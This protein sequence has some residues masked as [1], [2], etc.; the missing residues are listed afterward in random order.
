MN[1]EFGISTLVGTLGLST[2]VLGLAIG[3][4]LMS[5]L[6]EFYGRRPIYLSSW[7]MFLVWIIPSA[8][9]GNPETI[10]VTRFFGGFAGS[11]FL[12][13]AGGTVSDVFS[14]DEIQA[15]MTIISLSPFIGPSL[16]PL[17][18]G[19]INSN[20]YW[21]WT[22]YFLL[23]WSTVVL[24]CIVFLAPET[25]HPVRLREK[26]RR[27]RKETGDERWRAPMENM[28]KSIARTVGYS[29]LRPFQLL[30][31]E[32]MCLL[33][34]VFSAILLGCLYLFFGA[35]SL[36]FGGVYGFNLWQTGLAFLGI[37]TGMVAAAATNPLWQFAR[38][39]LL[40]NNQ[41]IAEPEFRLPPAIAGAVLVPTGLFW[42]AWTAYPWIHWIV[43][44]IG[45]AIFGMG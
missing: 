3:P 44:V 18:G 6:S 10:I 19:F 7:A 38:E 17:I 16:G 4:L 8:V 24:V 36:I 30:A 42:F 9:A 40:V 22:Y 2:F 5:P 20:T 33:L 34:C 11:A 26:A 23:I 39:R 14:R 29:L 35:F 28:T 25:Y 21:R 45:S 43:P 32:P 41:G 27:L 15:P 31:Y 37:F 1:P 12:S 13:V